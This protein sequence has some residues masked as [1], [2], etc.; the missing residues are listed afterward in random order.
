MSSS[1]KKSFERLSF[2]PKNNNHFAGC[3]EASRCVGP[4]VR[5]NCLLSGTRFTV[6]ASRIR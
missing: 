5:A 6:A 2:P 3:W 4:R 1:E